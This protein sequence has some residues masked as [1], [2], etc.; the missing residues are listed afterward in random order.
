M[1]GWI[2]LDDRQSA[3]KAQVRHAGMGN[4]ILVINSHH[5]ERKKWLNRKGKLI[6]SFFFYQGKEGKEETKAGNERKSMADEEL[7][8]ANC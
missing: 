6:V 3:R 4:K 1:A 8:I 5:K 2:P 7:P